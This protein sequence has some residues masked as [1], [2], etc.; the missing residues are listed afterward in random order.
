MLFSILDRQQSR[1]DGCK[2]SGDT[3]FGFYS[4]SDNKLGLHDGIVQGRKF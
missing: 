1:Y 2:P 4:C 3:F